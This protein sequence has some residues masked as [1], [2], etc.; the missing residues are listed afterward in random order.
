MLSLQYIVPAQYSAQDLTLKRK[1]LKT[2][3]RGAAT[4]FQ[5]G[6]GKA[7]GGGGGGLEKRDHSLSVRFQSMVEIEI[8]S[9][10]GILGITIL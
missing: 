4:F 8:V 10:L 3:F 6:R 9:I 2:D 1:K 7:K 5:K